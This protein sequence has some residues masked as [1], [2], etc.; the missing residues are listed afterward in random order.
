M[1]GGGLLRIYQKF[2]NVKAR[3]V[4]LLEFLLIILM[5]KTRSMI[6]ELINGNGNNRKMNDATRKDI[7]YKIPMVKGQDFVAFFLHARLP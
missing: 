6:N 3:R 2:G 4:E 1:L 7:F 5:L